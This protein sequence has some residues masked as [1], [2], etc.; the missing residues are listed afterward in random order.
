[1]SADKV[2]LK[3]ERLVLRPFRL[4]DVD[5]VYVYAKDPEWDRYLLLPVP[6]PYTRRNA[7]EFI[8]RQVL[9]SWS[10]DP[11]FAIVLNSA[12]VGGVGLSINE[13]H[14][15]DFVQGMDQIHVSDK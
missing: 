9:A 7:E 8:A 4:E 3:T 10:T 6:Q 11:H 12:V 5:D 13:I 1:M 15:L 2:E 14:K